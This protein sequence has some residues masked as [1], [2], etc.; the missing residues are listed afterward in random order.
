MPSP[1]RQTLRVAATRPGI[2]QAAEAFDRFSSTCGLQKD[3]V[4]QMQVALDE[5]LA[6]ATSH[7]SGDVSAGMVDLAFSFADGELELTIIDDGPAFD[8]LT[9]PE[10]DTH[11]PLEDRRPGGL[12]V[13]F[14]RS[15]MDR[16]EYARRDGRNWLVCARRVT[17]LEP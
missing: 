15:L 8:P 12:G 4:W 3:K 11:S 1:A 7:A 10:P 17:G 16:V 2:R 13:H 6:N 9:L 5:V 14:V